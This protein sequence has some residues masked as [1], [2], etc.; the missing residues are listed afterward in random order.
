MYPIRL[1]GLEHRSPIFE[2]GRRKRWLA[3]R[4][5]P[6]L[7][8]PLT[9]RLVEPFLGSGS[10]FFALKPAEALLAD[11][12]AELIAAFRGVKEIQKGF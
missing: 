12:N 10:I 9:A 7:G 8:T 6:V 4:L 2:V 5:G 11:S 3:P 1:E